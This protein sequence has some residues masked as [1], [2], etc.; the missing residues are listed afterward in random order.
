MY[1]T[2]RCVLFVMKCELDNNTS[3]TTLEQNLAIKNLYIKRIFPIP[4]NARKLSFSISMYIDSDML[5]CAIFLVSSNW[6]A[7][8]LSISRIW[9]H[10]NKSSLDRCIY[11]QFPYESDY[12]IQF[13]KRVPFFSVSVSWSHDSWYVSRWSSLRNIWMTFPGISLT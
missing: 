3:I 1:F 9:V 2:L 10:K 13:L 11:Q 4:Q 7:Y 6:L 8:F 12:W 5:D